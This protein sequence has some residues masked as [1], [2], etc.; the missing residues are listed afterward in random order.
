MRIHRIIKIFGFWI[1]ALILGSS[2]LSAQSILIFSTSHDN[3]EPSEVKE[4]KGVLKTDLVT[5][6]ENISVTQCISGFAKI[7]TPTT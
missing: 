3:T 2:P 7:W 5:Y 6:L 1:A 4:A